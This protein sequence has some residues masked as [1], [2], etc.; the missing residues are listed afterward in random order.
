M[1]QT[2]EFKTRQAM[3]KFISSHKIQYHEIFINNAYGIE[4]RFL[5]IIY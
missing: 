4:Y 5:K 1:W 3:E 2:K